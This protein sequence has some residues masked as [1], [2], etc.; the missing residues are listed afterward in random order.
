MKAAVKKIVMRRVMKA[1]KELR[2][3]L[4]KVMK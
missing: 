2:M 1:V 4:K 3:K